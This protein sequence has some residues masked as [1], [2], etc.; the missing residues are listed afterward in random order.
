MQSPSFSSR[1]SLA[2]RF[3]V[4]WDL[5]SLLLRLRSR[6][7]SPR[8]HRSSESCR[9]RTEG[10]ALSGARGARRYDGCG[11]YGLGDNRCPRLAR[12]AIEKSGCDVGRRRAAACNLCAPRLL[13]AGGVYDAG[14]K[15][16]CLQATSAR[17]SS[18]YD[19]AVVA[20]TEVRAICNLC[21]RDVATAQ[22]V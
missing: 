8:W 5:A 13:T 14:E 19:A 6:L 9:R 10:L 1:E 17:D 4:V 7:T 18:E 22:S 11:E 21:R 20:G 3:S 16:C 15:G 2:A 12:L